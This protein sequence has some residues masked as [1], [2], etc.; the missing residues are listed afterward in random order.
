MIGADTLQPIAG[1]TELCGVEKM[2]LIVRLGSM[3]YIHEIDDISNP[4]HCFLH[5]ELARSEFVELGVFQSC[6]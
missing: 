6:R 2:E 4:L 3:L 5:W 1:E